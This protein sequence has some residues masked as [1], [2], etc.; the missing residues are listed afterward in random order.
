MSRK[1]EIFAYAM[2]KHLEEHFKNGPDDMDADLLFQ[3]LTEEGSI[4]KCLVVKKIK[5]SPKEDILRIAA[6]VAGY[7]FLL[8]DLYGS[9]D[10]PKNKLPEHDPFG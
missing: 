4:L 5:D 9:F 6:E 3:Y 2:E 8:A 10:E 1:V 7:A